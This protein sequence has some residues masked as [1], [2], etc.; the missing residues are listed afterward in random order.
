MRCWGAGHRAA[1]LYAVS[2]T[3]SGYRPGVG[4]RF[5]IASTGKLA[6]VARIEAS[7]APKRDAES[8]YTYS[9]SAGVR[10]GERFYAEPG[11]IV[12]GYSSQFSNGAIWT[13]RSQSW[14]AALGYRGENLAIAARYVPPTK[15]AYDSDTLSIESVFHAGRVSWFL[16]P[17]IFRLTYPSDGRRETHSAIS[18]GIGVRWW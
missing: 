8:G 12:Y 5:D 10:L 17:S 18:G 1:Y 3:Q 2:D 6:A 15:D 9:A 11:A 14:Y 16:S 7:N 4:L 13:K